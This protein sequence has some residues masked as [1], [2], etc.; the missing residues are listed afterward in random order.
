MIERTRKT[1]LPSMSEERRTLVIDLDGTICTQR[2]SASYQQAKPF[3]EVILKINT[4]WTRG[5]RIVIHTARGMKTYCG[6]VQTIERVYRA[7][8]EEWLRKNRVLYDELIF[9]KP[10][11]DM[12][13]DDKGVSPDK[14]VNGNF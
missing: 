14:F 13:V 3:P 7:M 11:G 4:L 8:T 12:Y 10:A 6:D 5:W 2:D 1:G 9:G